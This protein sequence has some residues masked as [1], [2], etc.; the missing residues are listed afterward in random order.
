[1]AAQELLLILQRQEMSAVD[2]EF[3]EFGDSK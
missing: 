3:L 1:M 2:E